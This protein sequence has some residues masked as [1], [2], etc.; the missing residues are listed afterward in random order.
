[1]NKKQ[2]QITILEIIWN[3]LFKSN[4]CVC[5]LQVYG[6]AMLLHCRQLD[7]CASIFIYVFICFLYCYIPAIRANYP[8]R[9]KVHRSESYIR[10]HVYIIF[11][12]VLC[13]SVYVFFYPLYLIGEY[14]HH[15]TCNRHHNHYKCRIV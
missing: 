15:P 2:Q 1:M 7:L 14:I 9:N 12:S 3:N 13:V 4:Q 8:R 11:I 6:I 5:S 10:D